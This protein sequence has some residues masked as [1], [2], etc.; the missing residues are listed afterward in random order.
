MHSAD[1]SSTFPNSSL[2]GLTVLRGLFNSTCG[3]KLCAIDDSRNEFA[4]VSSA[5]VGE[6]AV[7]VEIDAFPIPS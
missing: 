1:L 5:T 7:S 4:S 2:V 3:H 6:L